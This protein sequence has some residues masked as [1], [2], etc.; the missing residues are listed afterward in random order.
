MIGPSTRHSHTH[1]RHD[2][3]RGLQ[4][5]DLVDGALRRL[6]RRCTA[7]TRTN[8]L[9]RINRCTLRQPCAIL[10]YIMSAVSQPVPAVV[11]LPTRIQSFNA[12]HYRPTICAREQTIMHTCWT[13]YNQEG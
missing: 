3:T 10:M 5:S 11:H 2:D 6:E 1:T 7:T 13:R 8:Q 12:T 9:K 4:R